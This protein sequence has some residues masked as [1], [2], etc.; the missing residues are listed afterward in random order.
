MIVEPDVA[1][2]LETEPSTLQWTPVIAG[3][4]AATAMS[5]ILVT[6]AAA[7][8]LGVSSTAHGGTRLLHCGFF[9]NLPHPPSRRE[10]ARP[11]KWKPET[12]FMAWRSGRWQSLSAQW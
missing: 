12:E 11:M 9:W 10:L 6:F 1:G 4:L 5:L 8:G 3:A 7:L 2:P